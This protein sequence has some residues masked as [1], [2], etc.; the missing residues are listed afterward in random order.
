MYFGDVV[1]KLK[2]YA[3]YRLHINIDIFPSLSAGFAAATN[4]KNPDELG[5]VYLLFANCFAVKSA[6]AFAESCPPNTS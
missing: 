3:L 5:I 6:V 4:A 2:S 1:L